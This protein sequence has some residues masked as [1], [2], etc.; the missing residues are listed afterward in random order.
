MIIS[1]FV[2]FGLAGC[3][4]KEEPAPPPPAPAPTAPAPEA[5]AGGLGELLNKHRVGDAV[6][7]R[8][9]RT[10]AAR[11]EAVARS[12]DD[13]LKEMEWGNISFNTPTAMKR[14][15]T[16]TIQL[17]L[18]LAQKIN[19]LSKM[20]TAEGEK[21][22]A[23]IKVSDRM[24]AHLSG[25]EFDIMP[26]TPEEQ[27]ISHV[28]TTEWKWRVK[29]KTVGKNDLHLTLTA[30]FDLNGAQT[31]RAIRTFDKTITVTV[32][33]GDQIKNFALN[34]WQ[35]LWAAILVP[36]AGWIWN[37]RRRGGQ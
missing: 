16:V 9:P 28:D 12:F 13:I 17:L 10:K 14:S 33:P 21:E 25:P 4:K 18:G 34:N 32:T 37:K 6:A 35:W 23:K 24:E 20:I 2:A 19:E 27:A 36:I 11:E 8:K 29:P 15:D 7:A 26:I 31:Q 22:G 30:K 3:G 5:P 1:V